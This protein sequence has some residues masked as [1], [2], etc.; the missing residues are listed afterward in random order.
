MYTCSLLTDTTHIMVHN[1]LETIVAENG[2]YQNAHSGHKRPLD[3][4]FPSNKRLKEKL[5]TNFT[6]KHKMYNSKTKPCVSVAYNCCD[7]FLKITV[8]KIH[9]MS[10]VWVCV[11]MINNR[12]EW[13]VKG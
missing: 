12:K 8:Q 13:S 2:L 4:T 10:H 9:N 6:F 7:F 3:L 5:R 11:V 1:P